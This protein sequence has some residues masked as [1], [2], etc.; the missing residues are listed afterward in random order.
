[1]PSAVQLHAHLNAAKD[2]LLA[3]LEV[4]A[5]LD[6]IAIVHRERLALSARL[7]KADVVQKC[8]TGRFHVLDVPA[9][10]LVPELAMTAT[11][12]LGLEADMRRRGYICTDIGLAVSL[13]V[14]AHANKL[15]SSRKCAGHGCKLQRRACSTRV[16]KGREADRGQ[17]FD[18]GGSATSGSG[19]NAGLGSRT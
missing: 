13:R 5:K 4:D 19:T 11:D 15:L 16:V 8:A 9:V 1:M 12:N 7:R 2:H 18:I 10:V 6:N 17:A 14:P 3:S